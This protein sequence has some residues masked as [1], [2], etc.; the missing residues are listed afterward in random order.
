MANSPVVLSGMPQCSILGPL[1]FV[2]F[3]ND[4][5]DGVINK[6]LNFATKI[7]SKVGSEDQVTVLQSHLNKMFIWSQDWQMLFSIDKSKVIH[8]G[9]NN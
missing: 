7:V 6:I 1:L 8:F 4:L 5:D 3:I 9:N 2:I